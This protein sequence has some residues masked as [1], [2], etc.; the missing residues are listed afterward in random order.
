MLATGRLDNSPRV[1]TLSYGSRCYHTDLDAIDCRR[2]KDVR[3]RFSDG[4][5]TRQR[6]PRIIPHLLAPRKTELHRLLNQT[7]CSKTP[8]EC[9]QRIFN[10]AHHTGNA[11]ARTKYTGSCSSSLIRK[12]EKSSCEGVMIWAYDG[13]TTQARALI[14]DRLDS[15]RREKTH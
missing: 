1:C 6:I 12:P 8:S 9:T 5:A 7:S 3:I 15:R 2:A 4:L 13:Q 11:Q 14:L 10:T